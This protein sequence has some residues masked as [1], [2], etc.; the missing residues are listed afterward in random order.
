MNAIWKF[1]CGI[2]S[3]IVQHRAELLQQKLRAAEFGTHFFFIEDGD[4]AFLHAAERV[5]RA[6]VN[7]FAQHARVQH[8]E[9]INLADSAG[10]A[11]HQLEK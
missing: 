7:K 1:G 8:A 4:I 6:R 9:V 10:K 3:L 2:E 11:L 5:E